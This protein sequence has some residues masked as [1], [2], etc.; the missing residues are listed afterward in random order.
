MPFA[1]SYKTMAP[2]PR[3]QKPKRPGSKPARPDRS[4]RPDRKSARVS[5]TKSGGKVFGG[6][7]TRDGAKPSKETPSKRAAA[8]SGEESGSKVSRS[9]ETGARTGKPREIEARTGKP[10]EIGAKV[11]R[12]I[13]SKGNTK[14]GKPVAAKQIGSRS[15][16]QISSRAD[17]D[18]QTDERP[19]K[20]VGERVE[21]QTGERPT[22]LLGER[23]A[24]QFG[25]RAE[26]QVDE[27]PAK[28]VGERTER[29]TGEK[30]ARQFGERSA[31]QFGERPDRRVGGRSDKQ[32]GGSRSDK[33]IGSSRPAK[34]IGGKF[35]KQPGTRPDKQ[36]SSRFDKQVDSRSDKQVGSRFNKQF[37]GKSEPDFAA[38]RPKK[39]FSSRVGAPSDDSPGGETEEPELIYGKQAV[40]TALQS[41]RAFNRIWLTERLRYDPRFLRLIDDAKSSGAVID[42]VDPKRLDQMTDN[43]NHQGV[44]A[45]TA[46]HAYT[47]LEELLILAEGKTN[48]AFLAADGIEDPYNLG[49]LIRSAEALGFLGILIPRRRA[50]GVTATVAKVAAGAIEHLPIA[51]VTNLN[52]ALERFKEGG[53][54]VVGAQ[55]KASKPLYEVDLSG[56]LVVVIGSEG[57]GISLLTQRH[58]DQIVSIPLSGKTPSLNASV[59]GGIVL[60]EVVRQRLGKKID[61]R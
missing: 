11:S 53:F 27:R 19:A 33:E 56:P 14:S 15:D 57:N 37:S 36:I 50:V 29:Q 12:P 42:I 32:L 3:P 18:Q 59:A 47:E 58:C 60:Y 51:R 20:R 28:R 10:K 35:D 49:A 23:S 7:A 40:L 38:N 8:R 52:Q 55:E 9:K 46:A 5:G 31:K 13:A 17:R 1:T 22:K 16:K 41:N 54:Q 25:E 24:K 43:G 39:A 48:P 45:Q 34:Q 6:K 4:A 2:T 61:M 26:R 30:P 44:A 21:R